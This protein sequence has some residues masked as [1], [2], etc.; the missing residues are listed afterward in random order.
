MTIMASHE[1]R[2]L[3][4]IR[5]AYNEGINGAGTPGW[6]ETVATQSGWVRDEGDPDDPYSLIFY[7]K[8]ETGEFT[9]EEVEHA[10]RVLT[11]LAAFVVTKQDFVLRA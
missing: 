5:R 7:R 4:T 6:G 8:D 11:R 2:M 9:E 1:N 3:A 10:H